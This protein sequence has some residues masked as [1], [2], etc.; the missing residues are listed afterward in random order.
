MKFKLTKVYET[1]YDA[2]VEADSLEEAIEQFENDEIE[3]EEDYDTRFCTRKT[4]AEL[5]ENG[6]TIDDGVIEES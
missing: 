4:W 2:E 3:W 1:Y 6:D 5:D